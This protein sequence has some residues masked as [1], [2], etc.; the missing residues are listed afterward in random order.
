MENSYVLQA[1]E[2]CGS[3]YWA[4]SLQIKTQ[5][6]VKLLIKQERAFIY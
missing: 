1:E 3:L 5:D 4:Q 6:G 2:V